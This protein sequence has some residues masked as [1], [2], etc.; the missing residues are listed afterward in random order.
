VLAGAVLWLGR[1]DVTRPAVAFG[2]VWFV[3]VALAQIRLTGLETPW[4][5]GFRALVFAG[6]LV[7]IA[8]ATLAG[9]T[10]PARGRISVRREDYSARRLVTAA[11]VLSA[12]GIAGTAYKAHVLGGVPLLSGQADVL[13]SR[14]IQGGEVAIP[15]WSTALTDGFFLALWCTLVALWVVRGT[16]TRAQLAGLWA[17]AAATLFG[18]ALLASRNTVLF[19]I[20]VPLFAVYLMARPRHALG[21]AAWLGAAVGIVAFVVGGLFVARLAQTDPGSDNFLE[22]ELNRHPAAVKPLVPFY[23][24][25]VFP[26]E[27]A[28]RAYSGFP[29]PHQY[30]LGG[31]SLTSLPDAAFPEGKSRYS[32][33]VAGLM[34]D[35]S[36]PGLKWTVAG[37]QGRLYADAGAPGVLLGSALLGI[38]FGAVYRRARAGPGFLAV[39]A[40]AFVAYYAAFMVY[41]NLL[42]FTVIAVFDL[43]MVGLLEQHARGTLGRRLRWLTSPETVARGER[44]AA[45]AFD[46]LV[47]RLEA[48]PWPFLAVVLALAAATWIYAGR[49]LSFIG[50]EWDFVYGR[51]HGG[52]DPYLASHN[53]HPVMALVAYYKVMWRAVGIEDYWPYVVANVALHLAAVALVFQVFRT[54]VGVVPAFAVATLLAFFGR[55]H[56]D[57]LWDFQFAFLASILCG[58]AAFL[59][60]QRRGLWPPV[61]ACVALVISLTWATWGLVFVGA[62]AVLVTLE[63]RWLHM[64]VPALP[65]A[66]F[67]VWSQSK[68]ATHATDVAELSRI[69]GFVADAFAVTL[70]NLGG[71]PRIWGRVLAVVVVLMVAVWLLRHRRPAPVQVAALALPAAA[72]FLAAAG[73][74]GEESADA[75]RYA[76]PFAVLLLM[77]AAYVLPRVRLDRRAVAV[78]AVVTAGAALSN[79]ATLRQA[80]ADGRAETRARLAQLAALDLAR[81]A[82]PPTYE[83]KPLAWYGHHTAELYF[84]AT[85][86]YG[87]PAYDEPGLLAIEP[88][89][90]EQADRVMLAAAPPRRSA[91]PRARCTGATVRTA[92]AELAP[93]GVVVEAAPGQ[94]VRIHWRRFGNAF[95]PV[96]PL[97]GPTALAPPPSRA[98]TPWRA[99]LSSDRPFR[100]CS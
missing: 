87:S 75:P 52:W 18:V 10:A 91:A 100:V 23:V 51:R 58:A 34:A 67:V 17:L 9:G 71:L 26:F 33:A 64:A 50:D 83:L 47:A 39:A 66:L 92:A 60:V 29:R 81:P 3:L 30:T 78:L 90:R 37:Y 40:I 65:A 35:P 43:A 1:R 19:A 5:G 24:N 59:L 70:A 80:T 94:Q 61:L 53:E 57:V 97:T 13:R 44:R 12:G 32:D 45:A 41:D 63:R 28:R 2:V 69:P 54:R 49:G 21:R 14:A 93:R 95:L 46:G 88:H 4:P 20:A 56:Q 16:A 8:A 48:R 38:L 55:A 82:V 62:I 98:R 96:E 7:F 72:F 85:D 11:L 73:R 77:A 89:Y 84:G 79:L 74:A 99:Q 86:A 31:T 22:R 36:R 76:W 68:Y 15:A 27:A 25:G 6:G 42:S